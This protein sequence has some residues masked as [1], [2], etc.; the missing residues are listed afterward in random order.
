[1]FDV[2]SYP[3]TEE[4]CS[5]KDDSRSAAQR[6]VLLSATLSGD[7]PLSSLV[8]RSL[9]LPQ[10]KNHAGI[11]TWE[12]NTVVTQRLL[13]PRR[14]HKT[15]RPALCY[16]SQPYWNEIS[17]LVTQSLGQWYSVFRSSISRPLLHWIYSQR[18]ARA[19]SLQLR[20]WSRLHQ[21]QDS[22]T[23][24]CETFYFVGCPQGLPGQPVGRLAVISF[25]CSRTV[26]Q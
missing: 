8:R 1:M 14:Q 21:R 10:N 25:A 9:N 2:F 12:S 3:S 17:F 5:E 20:P 18:E 26:L 24:H 11:Y 7:S 13:W 6:N 23:C 19:C 22:R 16:Y 15:M 4:F